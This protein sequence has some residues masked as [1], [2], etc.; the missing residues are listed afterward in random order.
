VAAAGYGKTTHAEAELPDGGVRCT[1]AEALAIGSV[2]PRALL[3]EDLHEVSTGERVEVL[4]TIRGLPADIPVTITSREPLDPE[5][6]SMLKGQVFERG[7]A[8][9]RLTPHALARVLSDEYRISDPEAPARIHAVTGGWPA[10]VHFAADALSRRPGTD[11]AGALSKPG[12]AA[13]TWLETNVLGPLP[14]Q[15]RAVLS[16]FAQLEPLPRDLVDDEAFAW[17][18]DL[19]L[20]TPHP[21]LE[22]LGREGFS[23]VPAIARMLDG[24][25]VPDVDTR[26]TCAAWYERSGLPFAAAHAYSRAGQTA[27][28]EELVASRGSEMIAQGNASDVVALV[29]RI[30][31]P[32]SS[33]AVRLAYAEALHRSGDSHAAM[34]A[35]GPLTG[36]ADA[37]GWDPGLAFR[38]A[39]VQHTQGAIPEALEAL[40]RVPRERV[41]DDVD[42]VSWRVCR[43]KV[44]SMLGHDQQARD[45]A[46]EA[47]RIAEREGDPRCLTE[48]H[49]AMA[50][51]TSGSGKEAHLDLA[52]ASARQAGDLVSLGAI[53]VN[54]SYV[55]LSSARYTEA[56]GAAREAVRAT[57]I[58]R[59]TGSLIAALHNLGEALTRVGEFAEARW[60]LER[61]VALSRRLGPNR[62]AAGL[63]GLGEVHRASGNHEQARTAYDE[64]VLLSRASGELQVLVPALAGLARLLADASSEGSE[65][66][67]EEAH[68]LAPPS[69]VS[70]A[71]TALGWAALARGEWVQAAAHAEESV[72]AARSSQ[73]L[74]LLAEALELAAACTDDAEDA[75]SALAEA[76]GIWR[77]GGAEPSACRVEIHLG[78]LEGADS[79]TRSR[80]REAARCLNRLGAAPVG[81]RAPGPGTPASVAIHVLGRFQ[82]LVDD[83]PVALTAW[84]SRQARTLV[85]ILVGRRGR[86]TTRA[87]LCELLWP[88]D[89]PTKTPHRL[90]VLLATVR[91]VLDP[92]KDWPAEHYVASDSSG[93]WLDLRRVGLDAESLLA[94]A[95]HAATLLAEGQTDLAREI[96]GD[97]DDRYCG[98][99]FEDEPY[100][101]WAESLRE[102]TRSAWLR[103]LRHLAILSLREGRMTDACAHLV[104]LLSADPYDERMHRALVQALVRTGR[105]GEARRAFDQ[106]VRAMTVVDAPRPDPGVLVVTPR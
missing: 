5:S 55:L 10:L 60:H 3:V 36:A 106:W 96:L 101:D 27:R 97:I 4:R 65:A 42:G 25:D 24:A 14:E 82:V 72:A 34:R 6:R 87:H 89:D 16:E 39:A 2:T 79:T 20:V 1:A 11:V 37:S 53:L 91:G 100:E 18:R 54:Q 28:A 44:L 74:D 41:S 86:P 92:G 48:A 83:Q 19:G 21:H 73:A 13:A 78:R 75:R 88:D 30:E 47:V 46:A 63:C 67:A 76:L 26:L 81:G 17:L 49:Q 62:I 43:A 57:E 22:L 31:S 56:V 32:P 23:V 80:A 68:R 29:A 103:S 85:K 15:V 33:P 71:L 77:Q 35:F 104:R 7:P 95:A 69:L 9:L 8:D 45:L 105:H 12:S 99:A 84:R 40:D 98:P 51:A 90:S 64:A 102:E 61:A 58:A 50:K 52:L 93:V 59:P 38:V 66:A 70:F 94:D